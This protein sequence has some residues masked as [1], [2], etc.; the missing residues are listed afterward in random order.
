MDCVGVWLLAA[1]EPGA[2]VDMTRGALAKGLSDP[3]Q[4][5]G[6]AGNLAQV[7]MAGWR[8]EEILGVPHVGRTAAFDR[9]LTAKDRRDA[10]VWPWSSDFGGSA[11]ELAEAEF[12]ADRNAA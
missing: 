2:D 6:T 9:T 4:R 11:R 1:G 5:F 7:V 12:A 3:T 8:I 10:R